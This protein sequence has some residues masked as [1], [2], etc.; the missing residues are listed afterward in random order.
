[1]KRI[2]IFSLTVMLLFACIPTVQ[3]ASGV[4][5]NSYNFPNELFREHV[6]RYDTDGNGVLSKTELAAVKTFDPNFISGS[7]KGI[8]Y[9][10]EL[11]SLYFTNTVIRPD[12]KVLESID[13]SKNTKLKV[14]ELGRHKLKRLDLS[15]NTELE[16]LD[17]SY[18]SISTLKLSKCTKLKTLNCRNNKLSELDIYNCTQLQKLNFIK[19]NITELD[20]TKFKQLTELYCGVNPIEK[21]DT[22]K[23]PNL[24]YFVTYDDTI[25]VGGTQITSLDFSKNPKLE[26]LYLKD[27]PNLRS[28]NLT[29]CAELESILIE[30]C[31]IS[32]PDLSDCDGLYSLH[33]SNTKIQ[34]LDIGS[35]TDL[36]NVHI[37]DTPI[38]SLD[39]SDCMWMEELSLKNTKITHVNINS[40]ASGIHTFSEN[41][42]ISV[43]V[44]KNRR[45]DLSTLPD[46]FDPSKVSE[47]SGAVID[48]NYMVFDKLGTTATYYYSTVGEK[49]MEFH[50]TAV[51]SV[52]DVTDDGKINAADAS[53][54]LRYDVKLIDFI[55][56]KLEKAD[57]N[58]DGEVNAADA[59]AILQYD[60]KLLF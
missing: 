48:G 28:I 34:S 33:L 25:S 5:I 59:S 4:S 16:V 49:V 22:S 58:G 47:L 23:N 37:Y 42:G 27:E 36:H 50:I 31:D 44:D 21:L 32:T 29:G 26:V 20:L 17:C 55:G 1:M 15:N 39:L 57:M 7:L 53:A 11:E 38:S 40:F 12:V 41:N 24:R 2:V 8:E 43:N 14:V 56:D 3:A 45:F 10:T 54:V 13:L 60:V 46:D 6:S 18:N 9:F 51:C 19:N 52:S 30:D 35:C